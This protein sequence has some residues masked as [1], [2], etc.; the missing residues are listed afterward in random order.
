MVISGLSAI[1]AGTRITAT[2][3]VKAVTRGRAA[4]AE[5]APDMEEVEE[6]VF[7]R[8]RK[9]PPQ[10]GRGAI[11]AGSS[12]ASRSSAGVQEQLARLKLGG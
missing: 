8:Q 2:T 5:S 1:N 11:M 3:R 4:A 6:I 10:Q 7:V 9:R 12:A